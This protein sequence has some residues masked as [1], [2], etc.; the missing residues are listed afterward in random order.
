MIHHF[1][2]PASA[3]D[4]RVLRLGSYIAEHGATVR[5]TA[6][7]FGISK[8]TVHKDITA[9]LP[10]LHAGLSAQVR[11]VIEKNKQERH[12]RG[13]LATKHKYESIRRLH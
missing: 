13:G 2:D 7:V 6:A 9:R 5:Q 3:L 11:A 12:I 10:A 4:E 8:S 1:S